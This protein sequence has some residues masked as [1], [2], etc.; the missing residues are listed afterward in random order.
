MFHCLKRDETS[1]SHLSWCWHVD[2]DP[3]IF[4]GSRG[5]LSLCQTFLTPVHGQFWKFQEGSTSSSVFIGLPDGGTMDK[6]SGA[7]SGA[8][9]WARAEQVR[10][11]AILTWQVSWIILSVLLLRFRCSLPSALGVRRMGR[12]ELLFVILWPKFGCH[13]YSDLGLILSRWD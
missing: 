7:V 3:W 13:S 4:I 1:L 10:V 6:C 11:F 5:Q 12:K 2:P 9:S 8:I